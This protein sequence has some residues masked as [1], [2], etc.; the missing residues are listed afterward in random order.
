MGE[1]APF[2]Y[3]LQTKAG[4]EALAH[5]LRYLTDNDD[6]VVI[7]S[8][9]GIGAFDH[10][11]RASFMNKT[12]CDSRI[13]KFGATCSGTIWHYVEIFVDG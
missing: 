6:E 2:Q 9:D 7:L 3:T 10:V 11:R 8:L 1:I 12:G 4:T 5:A 13:T